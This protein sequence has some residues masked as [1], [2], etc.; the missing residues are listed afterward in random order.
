MSLTAAIPYTLGF[1][2]LKGLCFLNS[3]VSGTYYNAKAGYAQNGLLKQIMYPTGGSLIYTYAQNTGSF[4]GSSTV[5]NVGGVHV[6]QTSSADGGYSNGCSN[7]IVTGYNYVVN[8]PGSA[9][10]LWGLE[11]PVNAVQ[12]NNYWQEEHETIHFSLS[13]P[14]GECL[15]HYIYPG[16]MSQYQAVSIEGWQKFMNAIAP[17]L[18]ILSV[19]ST[20]N[21]IVNVI[22]P[23]TGPGEIAAICIDII[24]AVLSYVFSC[25]QQTKTTLNTIYYNF[26]LN[27]VSPLPAQFKR[28]EITESPGTAGK[29]VEEFTHGDAS[30]PNLG[31]DHYYP[32]WDAAGNNKSFAAKQRFGPWAYGLPWRITVYDVNGNTIRQTQNVYDFSN[33][34]E[35]IYDPGTCCATTYTQ[36]ASC[37]C[38]VQNSYSQ[39]SD[40][41]S[42]P[43]SYISTSTF[44]TSPTPNPN[45]NNSI[46]I[47]PLIYYFYTGRAPLVTSYEREFRTTDPTQYVQT[48]K[49]YTY[50]DGAT[51]IADNFCQPV[52]RNYDVSSVATHLS[53]GDVEYKYMNYPGNYNTGLLATLCQK[54][55]LSEPV[56]TYVFLQKATTG[57]YENLGEEVTEYTQLANGYVRPLRLLEQRLS[58]PISSGAFVGYSGPTTTTYTNYKVTKS[59]TYD[60][61]SNLNAAQDEGGRE[62]TL[63]HDYNDKYVVA[64]VA[65]ADPV[66]DKPC[67]TSFESGDLSRSGWTITNYSPTQINQGVTTATGTANLTLLAANGNNLTTTSTLNSGKGY[68]LSFWSSNGNVTVNGGVSPVKTGPAYNGFT[69]YEY[70]IAQGTSTVTL[71]NSTSTNANID[72]VRLYPSTSRM[73]T[74]TYDQLIGKTSECDENNRTLYYTY[75]N[76]GRVQFVKDEGGN[77]AK[78]YEYNNV[79]AAKLTGCPSTFTNPLVSEQFT[80][81]NCGA[82]YQGGT[83]TYTVAAGTYS[84]T[85]SQLDVDIQAELNLLLNGPGYANTNG[86]CL[87]IYTNIAESQTVTTQS[88]APGY[89]GGSVTYTVPAGTYSSIISQADANQQALNDIAANAQSWANRPPNMS[90][91]INT[92]P[93]WEW[94]PGDGTS[95]ADPSYCA[96]LNGQLPPH[97]MVLATD[98][99]PNSPTYLQQ[100][101]EDYMA[102]TT[103]VRPAIITMC[104]KASSSLKPAQQALRAVRRRIRYHRASI[105]LLP[106]RLRPTSW[107]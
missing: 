85:A 40:G 37:K 23:S 21:D 69:Y 57:N 100:Q 84:S 16:I 70:N 56:E 49:D 68:I 38:Q 93:D 103:P 10:S 72:E 60:A 2:A 34:Q 52:Y 26:D 91:A 35:G 96:S 12:N 32:L 61:N 25:P 11:T 17:V 15:W 78:M 55:I 79:S 18:G 86:S 14:L 92:N 54:N 94:F 22:G 43:S 65:N 44:V 59:F 66:A 28:V 97:L 63:I 82:G 33:A 58:T 46:D 74:T 42:N 45:N 98:E 13:F 6:S 53:N 8:G 1:D 88:C 73:S 4:I 19:I 101:W 89:I 50:G 105:A 75:D 48:E 67:Y 64:M 39:R 30:D 102:P 9:S 36:N 7:P 80:R 99:N 41:W 20:I 90:C 77:V 3:G 87:L 47:I 106:A 51:C 83:V 27:E 24:T 31:T 95:P 76:L 29:T 71:S 104:R 62:I 107:P 5:Q 81:S